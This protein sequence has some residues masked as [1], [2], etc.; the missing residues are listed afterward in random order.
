MEDL[1]GIESKEVLKKWYGLVKTT[2]KTAWI[3]LKLSKPVQFE[4]RVKDDI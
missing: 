2:Q 3:G 4:T 1:N